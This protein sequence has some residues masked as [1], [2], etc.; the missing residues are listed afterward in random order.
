[1]RQR[2][3]TPHVMPRLSCVPNVFRRT[4]I[5]VRT[6]ALIST[7]TSANDSYHCLKYKIFYGKTQHK[8]RYTI[9]TSTRYRVCYGSTPSGCQDHANQHLLSMTLSMFNFC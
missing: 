3:T 7:S 1:M 8:L 9:F 4:Q 2:R 5:G 6:P